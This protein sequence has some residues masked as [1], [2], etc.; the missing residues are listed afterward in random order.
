LCTRGGGRLPVAAAEQRH[1]HLAL[2]RLHRVAVLDD[3][4]DQRAA[5]VVEELRPVDAGKLS[6][7]PA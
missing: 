6:K 7:A 2:L 4:F 1:L 5:L 3:L